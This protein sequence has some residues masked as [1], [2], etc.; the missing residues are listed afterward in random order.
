M[1]L[2]TKGTNQ[3]GSGHIW[4]RAQHAP[5]YARF[6]RLEVVFSGQSSMIKKPF[7]LSLILVGAFAL[8]ACAGFNLT[9][10]QEAVKEA[11]P[12]ATP[13][14][15]ISTPTAVP[16]VP[17]DYNQITVTVWHSWDEPYLPALVQI[18]ANFQ[19]IYPHVLFD[20]LYIPRENLLERYMLEAQEGSGGPSILLGPADWGPPL[21]D[22]GLLFDLTELAEQ[23][24][25]RT[26]NPAALRQMQYHD[27]LIG[28]PYSIQ[29]VVL[30]R[31][32]DIIP[33]SPDTFDD[34]VSLA[35]SFTQ[36]E[37]IGADLERGFFFSGGH[38]NGI[39]GELMDENGD[40]AFN[41]ETGV[42]WVNMLIEFELAGPTE[43]LSNRD[44]DLFMEGRVGFIIDG[45]WNMDSILEVL[46]SESI[47]IDPWPAYH[48]GFLAGYVQGDD[49]FMNG[50]V[51]EGERDAVWNFMSYFVSPDAQSILADVGLIPA[52]TGLQLVGDPT[53]RQLT[54]AMTA[55]VGGAAYPAVPEMGVY[56]GPMDI[57]LRSVFENG[58]NP[59][60][61]LQAAERAILAALDAIR[62]APTPVP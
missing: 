26:F 13:T 4:V 27:A 44:L 60:D 55:L 33:E 56:T 10:T 30:Y 11:S 35:R 24:L 8:S 2:L 51:N 47:V 18:I 41:D 31:N 45:T 21:Y 15:R 1:T 39:G 50:Q 28:L 40:P 43:Y 53:D 14:R 22:E 42:A 38:L 57:A 6:L 7:I 59:A 61:A 25:L 49:L 3:E 54:Q 46:G 32:R 17:D 58:V 52:V 12:E 9:G 62:T 48:D 16:V 19:A 34:L 20:V 5:K 37:V 29:G 23:D 36:G